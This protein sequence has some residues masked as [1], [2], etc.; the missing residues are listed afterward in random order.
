MYNLLRVRNLKLYNT[1]SL[2]KQ[3]V[4]TPF[5]RPCTSCSHITYTNPVIGSSPVKARCF[6]SYCNKTL[7]QNELKKRKNFVKHKKKF[8]ELIQVIRGGHSETVA[9]VK[10]LKPKDVSLLA[11]NPDITLEHIHDLKTCQKNKKQKEKALLTSNVKGVINEDILDKLN[12]NEGNLSKSPSDKSGIVSKNLNNKVVVD[13]DDLC[14]V[15]HDPDSLEVPLLNDPAIRNDLL[16]EIEEEDKQFEP[17]ITTITNK[18]PQKIDSCISK[19]SIHSFSNIDKEELAR[20]KYKELQ[21]CS[22]QQNLN[23]TLLSYTDVCVSCGFLNRGLATLQYYVKRNKQKSNSFQPTDIRIFDVLLNGFASKGKLEK[24]NEVW[25]MLKVLKLKPSCN[26]YAARLECIARASDVDINV[27]AAF[28]N[29]IKEMVEEGITINDLLQKC[30]FLGNQ[31]EILLQV[32]QRLY[33]DF[34]PEV[35]PPDLCYSC[36]LLKKLNE[37]KSNL[38]RSPVEGLFTADELKSFSKRQL[39]N[40]KRGTVPIKSIEKRKDSSPFVQ[41]YR[42]RL[43]ILKKLWEKEILKALERDI[44]VMNA[45]QNHTKVCRYPTLFPYLKVLDSEQL[46]NIIMQEI[47]KLAQGSESFSPT[48]FQ[49]YRGI[50][51]KVQS[52]YVVKYKQDHGILNKT[53]NLFKDYCE[54][55]ADPNNRGH[56]SSNA[57]QEWQQLV[58]SNQE[59]PAINSEEKVWP[60]IVLVEIGKFLYNIILRD[61]KI[62]VNVLR[63]KSSNSQQLLPAFYTIFRHQNSRSVEEIKPHPVLSKLFRA[64]E[65]EEL[66]F[67]VNF[68]PMACPPL[69]WTSPDSGGYLIVKTDFLRLP[70]QAFQQRERIEKVPL[71]QLYPLFDS[72]NQLGCVPWKVNSKVLDIMIEV[73]N[74]GGSSK[75]EVPEPPS[76]LQMPEPITRDMTREERIQAHKKRITVRRRKAEMYSLWCDALYRLSLANYFRDGIFWLPHNMDF[77]GRVYPCPPHLNHLGS[78]LARSLL[79]FAKGKPLGETG[80]DW[81]KIHLI[82]LTGVKKRNSV[83]D[84][85]LYANEIMDDIIDSAEKPLTGRMWWSES[86][87]PWQTLACCMEILAAIQ[88]PEGSAKYVSHFPIHQDGSCNG[89]Q[90]YAAL[91]R[92]KDGAVSVNL[93]PSLTPQDVYSCVA[94][95]VEE[96]R[97]ADAAKGIKVAQELDGFIQR[98]VIKQTVMTTVYGV[99]RFGARL[100]IAKQLKDIEAFPNEYVW[101]ASTYLVGKTFESLRQMFTSTREIQDWFTECARLISQMCGQNVEYVTPLGLPVV[102]PYV[103]RKHNNSYSLSSLGRIGL[104]NGFT[105]DMFERPNVMKQKNA[106]PPNFIHSLDSSHMMLTSLHCEQKGITFV[107]V[108]DCFWTHPCTVHIMNKICREQFVALHSQPILENL[109]SFLIQMYSYKNIDMEKDKMRSAKIRLNSILKKVPPKGK[110]E[111]ENVLDS[112]YFFS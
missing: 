7:I 74:N 42:D 90:H 110:F 22:K 20:F 105:A 45:A 96:A 97:A 80:L 64:T 50:G 103:R 111:L 31:R 29:V 18:K 70:S 73:F 41:L 102:Q 75:L 91:G 43:D 99:T 19:K 17:L 46:M 63:L 68:V 58:Y 39:E 38:L 60:T 85:L 4:T 15:V 93:S 25:S 16:K 106:F 88:H 26:S 82:N 21:D 109:S 3:V 78:D 55:Y 47:H 79:C 9:R 32:F 11:Q 27:D 107:S 101:S 5:R 56:N 37:E 8:A 84:R 28:Q 108:H 92:D 104:L 94:T 86:E 72:L 40:E 13:V 53:E 89:L 65:P 76:S 57:R 1:S 12:D 54:W 52:R 33:P 23:E 49:L 66:M 100:Q 87:T 95:I 44:N 51:L 81:L 77:R 98:K 48:T 6:S 2:S 62:D 10:N 36:S 35:A 14:E 83:I 112:I 61:I 71:P 34:K 59:G 67:D 30:A 69:P 24:L